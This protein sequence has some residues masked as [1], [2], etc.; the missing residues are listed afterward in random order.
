MFLDYITIK[1]FKERLTQNT[2]LLLKIGAILKWQRC[3]LV[4]AHLD[5]LSDFE[6]EIKKMTKP[7]TDYGSLGNCTY[8]FDVNMV[9]M[10]SSQCCV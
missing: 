2:D 3:T 9:F 10:C 8:T 1:P 7:T 6:T 4:L 5:Q